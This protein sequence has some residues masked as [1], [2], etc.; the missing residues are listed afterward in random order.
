VLVNNA[1]I[2]RHL[3]LLQEEPWPDTQTE[4]DTNLAAPI[5]LNSL[6]MQHLL[7]QAHPAIVNVTSGGQQQHR[8][9]RGTAVGAAAAST[10]NSTSNNTISSGQQQQQQQGAGRGRAGALVGS[11]AMAC[12]HAGSSQEFAHPLLHECAATRR[13]IASVSTSL[14]PQPPRPVLCAQDG[15]PRVLRHQGR[16]A[17]LH[18]QPETPASSQAPSFQGEFVRHTHPTHNCCVQ[19]ASAVCRECLIRWGSFCLVDIRRGLQGRC[20][21]SCPA[22]PALYPLPRLL[23]LHTSQPPT[24]PVPAYSPPPP[25]PPPHTHPPQVVELIPPA[26]N[27]DLGGP[28]LHTFGVPLDEFADAVRMRGW[29]GGALRRQGD[30]GTAG[31]TQPQAL[32]APAAEGGR[33]ADAGGR[34]HW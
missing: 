20:P 7:K 2:Q 15:C 16:P 19:L 28:G 27:T 33:G 17:L 31:T 6:F 32:V 18:P 5:H 11:S 29:G 8:A 9:W 3:D 21:L 24:H 1:G 22:C 14:P 34:E 30:V 4:L 26:V 23:L 12:R 10:S 25:P 13:V